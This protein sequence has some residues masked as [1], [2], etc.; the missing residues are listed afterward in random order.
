ML[1][2]FYRDYQYGVLIMRCRLQNSRLTQQ[3]LSIAICFDIV[4]QNIIDEECT[5]TI[6]APN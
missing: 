3:I 4:Y 1:A 2:V 5:L 6:D